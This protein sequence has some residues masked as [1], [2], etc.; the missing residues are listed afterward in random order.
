MLKVLLELSSAYSLLTVE[1]QTKK[2][3]PGPV[4]WGWGEGVGW[5]VGVGVGVG[6]GRP[7]SLGVMHMVT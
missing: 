6:G 7:L 2:P 5:G 3:D 4:H 1:N